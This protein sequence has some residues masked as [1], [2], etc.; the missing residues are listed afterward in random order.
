MDPGAGGSIE[1][2][3]RA[4]GSVTRWLQGGVVSVVSSAASSEG[5]GVVDVHPVR[6]AACVADALGRGRVVLV[7][8][9]LTESLKT[10][11]AD[12]GSGELS[13]ASAGRAVAE[14]DVAA[15][16]LARGTRLD[17]T[18]PD[19]SGRSA[20]LRSVADE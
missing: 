18:H 14:P 7:A 8:Q 11:A 20:A 9:R 16:I 6:S 1:I 3:R 19:L 5:N 10:A 17:L 4:L 12:S 2:G 13:L 15:S